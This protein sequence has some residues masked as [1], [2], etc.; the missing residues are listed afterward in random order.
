MIFVFVLVDPS[1]LVETLCSAYCLSMTWKI[2]QN[3]LIPIS[4]IS[5]TIVTFYPPALKAGGYCQGAFRLSVCPSV[6]GDFPF[7][8]KGFLTTALWGSNFYIVLDTHL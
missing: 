4:F 7:R 8:A 6:R 3:H 1:D 5:M 2:I